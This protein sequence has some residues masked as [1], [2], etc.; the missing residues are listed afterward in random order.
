MYPIEAKVIL[1]SRYEGH[2]DLVTL[3]LTYPRYIHAEFLTHRVFSRNASSSRA[4]PVAKMLKNISENP[5]MPIY[6]G[7][8]KPGMQAG[9]EL[10]GWRLAVAK[11]TWKMAVKTACFYSW[12]LNEVGLHKQH[13]NRGTEPYQ[14]ISVLVTSTEWSNF[15][16]LRNHPDAQPEIQYLAQK[17]LQAMSESQP[18]ILR[19][20]DWHL[21]FIRK[22]EFGMYPLRDLQEASAARCARVSY[23]THQGRLPE[24]AQDKLLF[25]K[26]AG[27][28]PIH[29]SPLEHIA[30][31]SWKHNANLVGWK[32]FRKVVEEELYA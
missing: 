27:S 13:A 14:L 1:H 18:Q 9:E 8:N 16:D 12:I 3:A 29:A 15:M 11:A 24:V 5:V 2:P 20:G 32:Q 6:W 30:V 17:M 28:T 4:I 7:S 19:Q 22:E 26:L 23:L 10:E 21:P 25:Q 31:P